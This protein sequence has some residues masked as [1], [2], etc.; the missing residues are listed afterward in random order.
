MLPFQNG[1]NCRLGVIVAFCNLGR[2]VA[3]WN[4]GRIVA[5]WNLGRIV[6]FWNLGRIVAFWNLG[7]TVAFWSLG[8]TV[9]F[10]DGLSLFG[11]CDEL[12]LFGFWAELSPNRKERWCDNDNDVRSTYVYLAFG[13]RVATAGQFADYLGDH[14][15]PLVELAV[16]ADES[17]QT[18]ARRTLDGLGTV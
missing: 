4:L 14:L 12:S 13:G 5:F 18:L 9:A 11:I 16:A 8:R 15:G 17:G 3:F 10:W 6:A 2:I 7:R 1:T